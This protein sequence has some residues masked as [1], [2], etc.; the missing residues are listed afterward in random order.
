MKGS[1]LLRAWLARLR[2]AG[3]EIR[4]RWRWTGFAGE[5]FAFDTPDGRQVLH[6]AVCVLALGGAS[7]PRLGSD[8]AWVPWL[9]ARGVPVAP[10]RPANMG[11]LVDWSPPM[12]RHFGAA[13]KGVAIRAGRQ[14]SRGEWVITRHG[15][16]GGGVYAIAARMREG[17]EAVVDL[18]PDTA[19]DALTEKFS[20]PRGKLSVG[21]WLRRVLGDPV[22]AALMLEWGRPLPAD[23]AALA[24][25]AKSLP[26]RHRGPAGLTR[27][28]SSAGGIRWDG[29]SEILELTAIPGC[30]AAGE[31]LDWEA[32]T[33]GYLLTFSMASGRVAARGA[34]ARLRGQDD[35]QR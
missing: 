4:T 21:N 13:V 11:F 14:I 20:R 28:I 7:W 26:L 19:A 18:A 30:F 10:F 24:A 34:L 23:H 6:P 29:L 8:A 33:G 2:D 9:A 5:G 1:P 16:E 27:A 22:R 12:A 15:F 17:A 3:V 35:R 31:M 32:P 25:L